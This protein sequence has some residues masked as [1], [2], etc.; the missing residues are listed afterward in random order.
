[1][2][3]ERHQVS[4]QTLERTHLCALPLARLDDVLDKLPPLRHQIL[5]I[6]SRNQAEDFRHLDLMGR[7]SASVRVAAWLLSISKRLEMR[8][9]DA[10]KLTL[11]MSRRDLGNYLGLAIETVSRTLSKLQADGVI[12]VSGR[13]VEIVDRDSLVHAAES[14]C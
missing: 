7:K 11:S 5:R 6:M 3:E 12:E 1:M 13:H 9:Y 8:G 4:A 2:D 14:E 10:D